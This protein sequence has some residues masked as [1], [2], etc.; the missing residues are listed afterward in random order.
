MR[1]VTALVAV[2]LGAGTPPQLTDVAMAPAKFR[3]GS[4]ELRRE[5]RNSRRRRI[6]RDK[7]DGLNKRPTNE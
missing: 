1:L 5:L 2:A 7:K 3:A 6:Y 4:E